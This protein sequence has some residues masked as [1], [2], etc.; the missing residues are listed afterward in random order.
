MRIF[1]RLARLLIAALLRAVPDAAEPAI[2]AMPG[3]DPGLDRWVFKGPV[4]GQA[5]TAKSDQ[6]IKMLVGS[7]S[8]SH[9]SRLMVDATQL[10]GRADLRTVGVKWRRLNRA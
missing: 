4:V 8:H 10:H 7:V 6:A 9:W 1:I 2:A 3:N 5:G